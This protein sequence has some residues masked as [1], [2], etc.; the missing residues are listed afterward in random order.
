MTIP[1]WVFVVM[2]V[3]DVLFVLS[4]LNLKIRITGK[5]MQKTGVESMCPECRGVGKVRLVHMG[6][7][8]TCSLCEGR[9]IIVCPFPK[10]PLMMR[11][12]ID[13]YNEN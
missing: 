1:T 2:L 8:V 3:G 10:P 7:W 11:D 5:F 12:V 9:K 13:G 6:M 4:A